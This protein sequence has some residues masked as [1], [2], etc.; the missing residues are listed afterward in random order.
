MRGERVVQ[1]MRKPEPRQR[2]PHPLALAHRDAQVLHKMLDHEARR[3]VPP[4]DAAGVEV[5]RLGAGGPPADGSNVLLHVQPGLVRV[6]HP[7]H[8]PNHRG[9]NRH[10]VGH[11][12]AL[13][14]ARPPEVRDLAHGSKEG[15]EGGHRG[16][17]AAAH[18]GERAIASPQ[19]SPG[20]GGVHRLASSLLCQCCNLACKA[21]VTSGHIYDDASGLETRQD[22]ILAENCLAHIHGKSHNGEHHVTVLCNL[23]GCLCSHCSF[24]TQRLRFGHGAVEDG[25]RKA[26]G[27]QVPAH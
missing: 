13:A 6:Q 21:R 5:E 10:L 17:V 18:D 3:H 15:G 2:Q 16:L 19:I 9:C 22:A 25:G 27:H 7:L 4:E 8:Q 14:G 24:I 12:A 26:S 20:D 23:F 11:F 1:C